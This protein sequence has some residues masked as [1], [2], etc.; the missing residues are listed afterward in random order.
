MSLGAWRD[1]APTA[2]QHGS[3]ARVAMRQRAYPPSPES[4]LSW[5]LPLGPL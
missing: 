3:Q 2:I 5:G 1:Q 4:R